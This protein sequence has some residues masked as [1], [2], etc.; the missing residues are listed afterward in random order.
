MILRD[1]EASD[2]DDFAEM[3]TNPNVTIPEGDLPMRSKDECLPVLR[4]LINAKNNYALELK[5]TGKVIGSAGL[6]EDGDGNPNARNLGYALNEAYWNKGYMTEALSE[7]I[8]NVPDSTLLTVCFP[9]DHDNEKSRHIAEK[10]GFKY[11]KT[12]SGRNKMSGGPVDYHYYILSLE[13]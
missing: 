13:K 4:Y 12:I 2:L 8:A 5:E 6:N 3:W 1:W 11:A 9:A 10:L 7:I